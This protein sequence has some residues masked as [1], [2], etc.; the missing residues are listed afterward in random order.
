LTISKINTK[1]EKL[2]EE[3][4]KMKTK[5]PAEM[6]HSVQVIMDDLTK[7]E[8]EMSGARKRLMNVRRKR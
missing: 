7:M 1:V 4:V 5:L 2:E 6:V 8:N 3:I